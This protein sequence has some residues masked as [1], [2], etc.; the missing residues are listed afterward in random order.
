VTALRDL[1]PFPVPAPGRHEQRGA[2]PMLEVLT[3]ALGD[4]LAAGE[5]T[6]SIVLQIG[7]E[8]LAE[9]TSTPDQVVWTP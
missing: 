2:S 7:W 6:T 4:A 3:Y 8:L 1:G 5:P 9:R